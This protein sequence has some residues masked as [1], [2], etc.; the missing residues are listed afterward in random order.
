MKKSVLGIV[1][2]A[3]IA[4]SAYA[5]QYCP[6]SDFIVE[7]VE[8]GG[9][10]QIVECIGQNQAVRIPSSINQL[11]VTHIEEGAFF[12][13]GLSTVVIPDSVVYIGIGAFLYN[14]PT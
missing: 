5:Q 4:L 13:S 1:L 7:L 6:A 8:G 11:P 10:V 14:L 3:T 2:A 12:E 9:S